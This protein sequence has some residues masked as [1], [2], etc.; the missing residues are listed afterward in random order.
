MM[1]YERLKESF[2]DCTLSLNCL[3]D[4][5]DIFFT[6][7]NYKLTSLCPPEYNTSRIIKK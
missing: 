7:L 4:I 3:N 5:K 2:I 6:N 1:I